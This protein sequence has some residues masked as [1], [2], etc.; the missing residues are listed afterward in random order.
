GWVVSPRLSLGNVGMNVEGEPLGA[1]LYP[2]FCEVWGRKSPYGVVTCVPESIPQKLKA[3]FVIGGNPLISMADSNAFRAA[4]SK[5]DLLVV[6]DMFMTQT[7]ELAHY[8]L[9]ACSHL[10]KWGLAYTYNV[11]HCLPY[12]MLRKKAIEPFY[13]SWSEWKLFTELSRRMGM[14]DK[15]PWRSEEDLVS[16]E[17]EP[18]GLTFDYL[19]KVKPEGDYYQTKDYNITESTFATPSRKIEI[20]SGA[21]EGAGFDALPTYLE[22]QRSP[23][24]TPELLQE[25]PLILSTGYRNRYYTHTQFREIEPLRRKNPEARAEL[26]PVTARQYGIKDDDMILIGTNKGQVRMKASVSE[27]VAEGIVLVPHGW[28]GEA[29]AN[30]LTDTD[31]REPIMGYPEVKA[32]LCKIQRA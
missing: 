1:D 23:R 24:S 16:F 5:L 4:F 12:L 25:Y 32:L 13:E 29:N 19:M 22:P 17:L 10:E 18:A 26:G 3:F 31:C 28:H 8:V 9:P 11:C 20:Y 14:G 27:R 15:F 21:L 30:L 6:H 2:L 7:A